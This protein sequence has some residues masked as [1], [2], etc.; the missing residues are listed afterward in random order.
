MKAMVLK[1]IGAPL[2]WSDLPDR[3]PGAGEIRIKVAAY[4]V[5]RTDLH[6]MDGVGTANSRQKNANESLPGSR[7]RNFHV[8]KFGTARAL[9]RCFHEGCGFK[10]QPPGERRGT[11]CAP[12]PLGR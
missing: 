6:V 9:L 7:L 10:D 11:S 5:C 1:K 2:D 8:P 12:P 3:E 4:G